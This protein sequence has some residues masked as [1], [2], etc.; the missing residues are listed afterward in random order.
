MKCT[1]GASFLFSILIQKFKFELFESQLINLEVY[2]NW[3][4]FT[5]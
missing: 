4:R 5:L 2:S 3:M 1:K